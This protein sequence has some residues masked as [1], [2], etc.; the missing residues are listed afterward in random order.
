MA[1]AGSIL[2]RSRPTSAALALA[3]VLAVAIPVGVLA[4]ARDRPDRDHAVE[5]APVS[6]ARERPNVILVIADDQDADSFSSRWMPRTRRL[7][8]DGGTVFT[9]AI[10]ATPL[11]CPSRASLW[12]GNY[13]HNSGVFLNRDGYQHVRDPGQTLGVWMQR[14]GYRTAWIGK[15]LQGYNNEPDPTRP[16]PGFDRWAVSTKPRYFRWKLF[17]PEEGK[18]RAPEHAH[19]TDEVNRRA[20]AVIAEE[21][22]GARPLFLVVNQLA[23][24]NGKGG[25][26]RCSDTAAVPAPRDRGR[27]A[28]EP[29]PR[30]PSFNRA[31]QGRA[32]FGAG[33]ALGPAEVAKLR[34]HYRCRLESLAA[35]DRGMA[36]IERALRRAGELENTVLAYTSDNGMLLG[37][38]ALT[39]KGVPY[40][41]GL[42]VPLAIRAPERLL[43][44]P[45][46]GEVPRLATNVDLTA[47]LLDLAGA[48]ACRA[49]GDCR[50]LDGRSL[51]PLIEGRVGVW[52]AD[53]AIP[54]E[55]GAG[56]GPCGY[57]G[58]RLE[59]EVLLTGVTAGRGDACDRTGEVELYDLA[60]DPHQLRD[61]GQRPTAA[62]RERIDELGD[63]LERLENCSGIRGREDPPPS[64]GFCE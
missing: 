39:G 37:E 25:R 45:A 11:C 44:R 53:R 9:Q 10:A 16:A 33:S 21:T 46:V 59:R 26:G 7:F 5:R 19:Y 48:S 63:R 4:V 43:V 36:G 41:E 57:R 35:V 18:V 31:G 29:L 38:H 3:A 58:L 28:E 50:R 52:P 17:T 15:F 62:A 34:A 30:P 24:H 40:E 20:A 64:A 60:R 27:A 23:P 51:V 14:A 22:A 42:R 55:G 6:E 54:I 13:P 2:H 12:T 47:T 8:A 1:A 32:V 56:G 61:L 49:A